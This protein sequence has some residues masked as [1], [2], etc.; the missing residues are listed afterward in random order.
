VTRY[1]PVEALTPDHDRST[2]DCGSGAQTEWLRRF[3]LLAQQAD[4]ARVYVIRPHGDR[5]VAGYYALAAGAVEGPDAPARLASGAGRHPILMI[6]LTR[7]G[8]DLRNQ[9]RGLGAELV[10]DAFLQTAAISERVGARAL[11]IHAETAEAARFYTRIDPAFAPSPSDPLHLA[12][13]MK[14]LRAAIRKAAVQASTVRKD[15][16]WGNEAAP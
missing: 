6:I 5:R 7:L 10:Y 11:L 12:L 14:D 8:V 16:G 3:A 9:G 15:E 2:F 13:L 1:A 4:T